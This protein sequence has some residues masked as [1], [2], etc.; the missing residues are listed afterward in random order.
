MVSFH[1]QFSLIYYYSYDRLILIINDASFFILDIISFIP[2]M[3]ADILS[4][5]SFLK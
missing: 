2:D 1:L 5:I 4:N 3:K